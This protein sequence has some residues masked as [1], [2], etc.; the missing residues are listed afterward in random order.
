MLSI[1]SKFKLLAVLIAS[2]I[3][4]LPPLVIC[5]SYASPEAGLILPILFLLFVI[6]FWLTVFRTRAHKLTIDD[7]NIIVNKYFG[8]GKS[9]MYDISKLDGFVTTFESGKL[10][11]SEFLFILENGKRVACI[12]SFYQSNFDEL[13][14]ILKRK[15]PDLGEKEY[16]SK[17][18]R[19][20]V[21]R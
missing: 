3:T 21:L 2:F 10:G 20:E 16:S 19:A 17:E 4:V 7:K 13:K 5:L 11:V 12:S 15:I 18:E 1:A 8:L 6:F 9:K 14:E